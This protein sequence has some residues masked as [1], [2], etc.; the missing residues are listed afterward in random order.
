MIESDCITQRIS[1]LIREAVA[2]GM[3]GLAAVSPKARL[4]VATVEYLQTASVDSYSS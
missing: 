1:F 4:S 2:L 3:E